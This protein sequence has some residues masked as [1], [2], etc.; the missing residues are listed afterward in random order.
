MRASE[1]GEPD[2][3]GLGVEAAGAVLG[4]ELRRVGVHRSI[5]SIVPAGGS[6]V[7]VDQDASGGRGRHREASAFPRRGAA[8][9]RPE[10]SPRPVKAS[11]TSVD[12]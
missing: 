11:A 6:P 12:R 5:P 7:D 2:L 10:W 3:I 1:A 4:Q 9:V 8:L